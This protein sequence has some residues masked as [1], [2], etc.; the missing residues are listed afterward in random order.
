MTKIIQLKGIATA[1]IVVAGCST[2]KDKASESP[3]TMAPANALEFSALDRKFVSAAPAQLRAAMGSAAVIDFWFQV[4]DP[5]GSIAVNARVRPTDVGV[6]P[7]LFSLSNG[8]IGDGVAS[9]QP[10][11]I[12]DAPNLD[13][14]TVRINASAGAINGEV[15]IGAGGQVW[16]FSGK[17]LVSCWVPSSLVSGAPPSG[18]T[19]GDGALVNDE[20]FA[21]TP[22]A[23]FATWAGK[24]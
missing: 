24:N 18:G 12:P 17:L 5:A 6:A 19:S 16:P 9:V 23:P 7:L 8:P 4:A 22:C 2:A 1:L 21:S 20:S 15:A 13:S 11:N 3:S 14:G 10:T